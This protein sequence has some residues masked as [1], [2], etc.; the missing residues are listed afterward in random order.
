MIETKIVAK[1]ATRKPGSM[2]DPNVS[3]AMVEQI[4]SIVEVKFSV[5]FILY[6]PRA[7]R[8]IIEKKSNNK[9][10]EPNKPITNIRSKYASPSS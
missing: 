10:T 6:S 7:N 1:H 4:I 5:L 9:H 2:L 3:I 8:L